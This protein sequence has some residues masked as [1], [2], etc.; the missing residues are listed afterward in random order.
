[1]VV[2]SAALGYQLDACADAISIA[3][4]AAQRNIQPVSCIRTAVHPYLRVRTERGGDHIDAPVAIK[5]AEGAA[6]VARRR[7]RG[8][9]GFFGERGPLARNALD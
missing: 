8:Q 9:T 1:M 3:L 5:I 4:G 7:H 2:L 6:T